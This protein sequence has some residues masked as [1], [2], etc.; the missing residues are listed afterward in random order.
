MLSPHYHIVE[1]FFSEA[2]GIRAGFESHFANPQNHRSQHQVW[3]YWYVPE[4]YTYLKTDPVKII[5]AELLQRFM[6]RLNGWAMQTLGLST[7]SQPYLSLYVN[8]CGQTI[9]N[10]SAA[11]QMGYVFSITRWDQRN[12]LGGETILFHPENYWQ[13]ERMTRSGAG[14][15][16]YQLVPSRFNQLL[17]FDDRVIHGVQTIQGTMDPLQ[18]R[19]VIHGHLRADSIAI[20]GPLRQAEVSPILDPAIRQTRGL[21]AEVKAKVSGFVTYRMTIAQNG[22]VR[23]I[24]PLC[25]RLLPLSQDHEPIQSL[26]NSLLKLLADLVFP[27][28]QTETKITIPIVVAS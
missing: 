10:D 21:T 16:F 19:L 12:F 25:D 14:S 2:E 23:N 3:N 22:T 17:V 27:A 9:H 15:S 13:S 24:E 8:G 4:A 26:R 7:Q 11:G 20:L 5:S 28:T 1:S 18:G 6:A